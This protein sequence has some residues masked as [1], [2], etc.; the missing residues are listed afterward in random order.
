MAIQVV[1]ANGQTVSAA[2]QLGG[3]RIGA[4]RTPAALTGVALTFQASDAEGGTYL[5]VWADAAA[6]SLVVAPS[7]HI[8]LTLD[9]SNALASCDWVKLVSG[10]AEAAERTLSVVPEIDPA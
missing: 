1:I 3:R 2:F 10:S 7:R 9:E 5:P 4:I 8:A 6:V